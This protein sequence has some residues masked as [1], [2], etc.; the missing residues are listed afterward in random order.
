ME[1]P[2]LT[3]TLGLSVEGFKQLVRAALDPAEVVEIEGSG[4]VAMPGWLGTELELD[5]DLRELVLE[6]L[7]VGLHQAVVNAAREIHQQ[8]SEGGHRGAGRSRPGAKPRPR[9]GG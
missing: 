9:R 7:T 3:V 1:E 2:I 5:D 8:A 6:A 4:A